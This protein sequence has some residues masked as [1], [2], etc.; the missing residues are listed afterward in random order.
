MTFW[1]LCM[2]SSFI[3]GC[4]FKYGIQLIQVNIDLM[5]INRLYFQRLRLVVTLPLSFERV[6]NQPVGY[7]KLNIKRKFSIANAKVGSKNR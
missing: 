6:N 7:S 1:R 5:S 4:S 2:F 3:K